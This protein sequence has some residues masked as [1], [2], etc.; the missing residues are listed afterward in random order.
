MTDPPPCLLPREDTKRTSLRERVEDAE[1]PPPSSLS[2]KLDIVSVSE[3]FGFT[4]RNCKSVPFGEV[5]PGK[6]WDNL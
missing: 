5:T 3:K 6:K 1:V 2:H 4:F